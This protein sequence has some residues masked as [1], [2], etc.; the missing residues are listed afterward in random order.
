[1]NVETLVP[2][3][4][5][6]V[7]LA[8]PLAVF[9]WLYLEQK[10]KNK[11][12]LELSKN[13]DDP[14]KVDNLMRLLDERKK[15]PI[16]YRR[17]GVITLFTGVGLFLFGVFFLGSV[18]KGVG[19]LVALVG[20]GQIIAGYLYPNTSEEITSVVDEFEKNDLL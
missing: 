6:V 2:L 5:L 16:D 20:L 14:S 3:G 7:G 10:D 15:Q 9:L 4:G 11:T 18:L 12:I 13:I 17:T 1:M 8:I 19:S